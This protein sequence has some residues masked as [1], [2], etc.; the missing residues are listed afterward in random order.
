MKNM[1]ITYSKWKD[2]NV[3]P[4]LYPYM[5]INYNV[6]FKYVEIDSSGQT[7]THVD[8]HNKP[9]THFYIQ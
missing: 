3:R 6:I 8:Y 9:V 7:Q 4:K 5:A 1:Y 2:C